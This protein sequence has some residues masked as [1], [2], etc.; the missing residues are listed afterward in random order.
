MTDEPIYT[1]DTDFKLIGVNRKACE[2]IGY[3]EEE[4]LGRNM[5]EIGILHPDDYERTMH[6]VEK[7]FRGEMA[8]NELRFVIKKGATLIGNITG[9]TLYNKRGRDNRLHQRGQGHH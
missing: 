8:S 6:H 4:M 3:S 5:L 7:L 2:L 1:Y 9:A